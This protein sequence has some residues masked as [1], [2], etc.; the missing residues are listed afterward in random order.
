MPVEITTVE[1]LEELQK[2]PAA[3]Q[4]HIEETA[5]D[6]ARGIFKTEMETAIKDGIKEGVSTEQMRA[7][8]KEGPVKRLGEATTKNPTGDREAET[9]GMMEWDRPAG[10][11]RGIHP[12]TRDAEGH[13]KRLLLASNSK[14]LGEAQGDQGGFLVPDDFRVELLQLSLEEAVVRPRARIFPM[15][16]P[17]MR[18]PAIV[19][20]DHSTDVFGGV[21]ALWTPESGAVTIKEPSFG[22]VVLNANKLTGYTTISNE[23]L[24]DSAIPMESL[25]TQLFGMALAYFEDDAFIAG[26]GVGQPEGILNSAAGV[27]VAKETGQA[28]TTIVTENLDKMYSR[29]LPQSLNNAIWLAHPDTMPQLAALSRA[30]GTGGSAVMVTNMSSG[31]PMSIYGRPIIFSEKCE[32]LGTL[33]DIQF[34]DFG[35]YLVGDRM[36]MTM[37]ASPHVRFVNDETVFRFTHRVDGKLWLTAPLTPRNGTNTLSPVVRLAA[38]A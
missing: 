13:D 38:R 26:T 5:A 29:M 8:L 19:D 30:V 27:D 35:F 25:L 33:G 17:T 36:A 10:Y 4:K 7:A 22:Q 6:M 1:E 24:A 2:D 9:G 28:A 11:L 20:T 32:T 37:A 14:V 12:L 23:L 3:Y 21:Q 16:G 34:V 18:I 15:G 31:F